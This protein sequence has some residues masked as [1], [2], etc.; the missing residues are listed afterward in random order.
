MKFLFQIFILLLFPFLIWQLTESFISYN[1]NEINWVEYESLVSKRNLFS[2]I[3]TSGFVF[4]FC[5]LCIKTLIA[6]I[7]MFQDKESVWI[8]RYSARIFYL[9]LVIAILPIA[10]STSL[11]TNHISDLKYNL[12]DDFNNRYISY[13]NSNI[14]NYIF[15]ESWEDNFETNANKA[16][17]LINKDNDS[18]EEFL[19]SHPTANGRFG[20]FDIYE[21]YEQQQKNY[22]CDIKDNKLVTEKKAIYRSDTANDKHSLD[23]IKL[24]NYFGKLFM[25]ERWSGSISKKTMG[26]PGDSYYTAT[27]Y[28]KD[29]SMTR[30]TA[31]RKAEVLFENNILQL[32][33]NTRYIKTGCWNSFVCPDAKIGTFQRLRLSCKLQTSKE[34]FFNEINSYRETGI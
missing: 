15:Q 10:I 25:K 30:M 23:F 24:E 33:E 16:K 21:L 26:G 28:D 5:F 6:I 32:N 22:I 1:P 20:I 7:R 9:F 14:Y 17:K 18:Y 3:F 12:L 4:I 31:A 11:K 8:W 13:I 2:R 19:K 34:S 29:G 27:D